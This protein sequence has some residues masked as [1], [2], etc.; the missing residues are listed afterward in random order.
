M[1]KKIFITGLLLGLICNVAHYSY[2]QTTLPRDKVYL[3]NGRLLEGTIMRETDD[4]I[5]I[6]VENGSEIKIDRASIQFIKKATQEVLEKA[7]E[8]EEEQKAKGL[9]NFDGQWV[10][11]EEHDKLTSRDS[12]LNEIRELRKMKENILAEVAQ[13]KGKRSYQNDLFHFSFNPPENWEQM[14][15]SESDTVCMFR[16]PSDDDFREYIKVST[17][18]K[19]SSVIDQDFIDS[20]ISRLQSEDKGYLHKIRGFDVVKVDGLNALKIT[21]SQYFFKESVQPSGEQEPHHQKLQVY[22]VVGASHLYKIEF[23]ALMKNFDDFEDIFESCIKSFII[24]DRE[25]EP[26]E[27]VAESAVQPQDGLTS[28]TTDRPPVFEQVT[29]YSVESKEFGVDKVF[30]KNERR[31]EGTVL[32]ESNESIRLRVE[33]PSTPEYVLTVSRDNIDYIEWM[34]ED[35]RRKKLQYEEE[36]RQKGLVRFYGHWIP[37]EQRN[38]FYQQADEEQEDIL[39]SAEQYRLQEMAMSDEEKQKAEE[40][41]IEDETAQL[42][43]RIKELE[44]ENILLR[45]ELQKQ[46]DITNEKLDEFL[47]RERQEIPIGKVATGSKEGVV[48]ILVRSK[49]AYS[50]RYQNAAS[51]AI[52]SR[53]GFIISNYYI[54]ENPFREQ[55]TVELTDGQQLDARMVEYDNI[56]DVAVIKINAQGLSPLTT[57]NSSRLTPGDEIIAVGAPIGYRDSMTAGRVLSLDS[58]LIDLI[59]VNVKLRWNLERKYGMPNVDRLRERFENDYGKVDMIQHNAITYARNTGGPLLDKDGALVGIN[60]NFRQEGSIKVVASPSAQSFNMAIS[61]NSVKRQRKFARYLQ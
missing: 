43:T 19:T 21:M 53:D 48:K 26:K 50:G 16:H 51:G 49:Y 24:K 57:G 25:S 33:N 31:L 60:Q 27:I 2:G 41:R 3:K 6:T 30:F 47:E 40:R 37:I 23:S 52:I 29:Q 1:F 17:A 14:P 15:V 59:D 56:L 39:R 5:K 44:D 7:R 54:G 46:R 36:Q 11:E 20:S 8:F 42:L 18:N 32:Q 38:R 28:Q 9:V 55:W 10:T 22:F 61:I 12:L 58:R 4:Y 13:L 45:E 34:P 35:E